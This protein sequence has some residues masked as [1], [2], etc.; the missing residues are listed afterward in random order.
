MFTGIKTTETAL[1]EVE[2]EQSAADVSLEDVEEQGAEPDK[3]PERK[4]VCH[5]SRK[6]HKCF[7]DDRSKYMKTEQVNYFILQ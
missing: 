3:E 7:N 1:S 4:K 6:T 2:E 5:R